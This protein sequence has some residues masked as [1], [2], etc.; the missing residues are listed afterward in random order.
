MDWQKVLLRSGGG[1]SPRLKAAA[2]QKHSPNNRNL[3]AIAKSIFQ[4]EPVNVVNQPRRLCQRQSNPISSHSHPV[5][6]KSDVDKSCRE[7]VSHVIVTFNINAVSRKEVSEFRHAWY[8]M[9]AFNIPECDL[10]RCLRVWLCFCVRLVFRSLSSSNQHKNI[11]SFVLETTEM[12][13][14]EDTKEATWPRGA[15]SCGWK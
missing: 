2:S 13:V 14:G 11:P 10:R 15:K 5:C 9:T 8:F 1:V 12:C 6:Y 3:D 7:S 4:T